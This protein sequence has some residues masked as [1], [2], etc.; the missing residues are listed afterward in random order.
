LGARTQ[1]SFSRIAASAPPQ[2]T[3][4]TGTAQAVDITTTATG[5]YVPAIRR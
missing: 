3:D 4:R 5:V 1:K 2:T